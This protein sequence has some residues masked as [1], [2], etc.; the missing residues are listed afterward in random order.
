M[1]TLLEVKITYMQEFFKLYSAIVVH[2]NKFKDF[3]AKSKW[4][5]Q[6]ILLCDIFQNVLL[7]NNDDWIVTWTSPSFGIKP[8]PLKVATFFFSSNSILFRCTLIFNARQLL[9]GKLTACSMN[10]L[11]TSVVITWEICQTL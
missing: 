4:Q 1:S 7:L 9:Q 8:K 6:I 11:H 3:L 2:I 10:V 5:R